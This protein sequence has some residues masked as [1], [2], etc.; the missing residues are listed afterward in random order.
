MRI[1]LITQDDPFYL[2]G[3]L[4]YLQKHRDYIFELLSRL[5]SKIDENGSEILDG[6]RFLDW[7]TSNDPAAI[8]A[9]LQSMM[10]MTFDAGKEMALILGDS[11]KA[12]SCEALIQKLNKSNISA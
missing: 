10:V 6:H 9:G 12:A 5:E 7:P 1:V 4:D 8:H 11:E 2:P 3:N